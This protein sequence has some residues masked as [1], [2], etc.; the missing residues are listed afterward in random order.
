MKKTLLKFITFYVLLSSF[1][2]AKSPERLVVLDPASIEIIYEL[3]SG[4]KIV[5]IA[6]LQ[7]S[8]IQPIEK[9]IKLQSVGTFSNPS[10]EKIL[11]LKPDL[12][13]L[14]SYS[15]ALEPRLK[16]L[17]IKSLYLEAWRLEDLFNNVST[18]GEILDKK[19]EAKVLNERLRGEFEEL[20][21][22]PINKSAIFLFSSNPL[23]AFS[24][25]SMIADILRLIGIT[26]LTPDSEIKRPIITKEYIITQNPDMLLLG[27]QAKSSE[28]LI[29][30]NPA[31]KSIKAYQNKEIFAYEPIHSLLRISP[32]ITKQIARFKEFIQE[33]N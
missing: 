3:G 18:L 30:Q 12:V 5:A 26:N 29:A 13:I 6:T 33:Q 11:S 17:G 25:N 20:K 27:I 32:N 21:K 15:L 28:Q 10:V 7:Q 16:D 1:M 23:M 8:N 31:L 4:D 9:T 22:E 2:F 19:E 24:N 14:S